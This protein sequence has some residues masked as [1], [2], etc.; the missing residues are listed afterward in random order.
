MTKQ[1]VLVTGVSGYVASYVVDVLIKE[2]YAVRGTV[3]SGKLDALR[4][5]P[6]STKN[7]DKFSV[8]AIDDV[9]T[10]DFTEALKDVNAV[11]HVASP[12]AGNGTPTETLNSARNGTL[13]VLRQATAQ[14]IYKVVV[15][16]S[17]GAALDPTMDDVY[18]GVT[19]TADSWGKVDEN[20]F[21]NGTHSP[22]WSYLAAKIFA[23]KA[24]WEFAKSNPSLDLA[25]INPPFIY[26]PLNLDFPLPTVDRLGPN[27][28]LHALISGEPGR[29]LGPQVPPFYVD[30]RDV[31][32]AHVRALSVPPAEYKRYL[33]SAGHFTFKEAVNY[34]ADAH[35]ELRPRLPSLEGAVPLAGNLSTI[36]ASKAAV[37]L[38]LTNYIPW[39]KM[40]DDA[41]TSMV[42]SENNLKL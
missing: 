30:V 37:D 27:M 20:D 18:N 7:S 6:I 8:V 41:V 32:L 35:P 4:T 2:G 36:D 3:R 31:A 24:A 38:K 14:G 19:Y 28:R 40:V 23:E 12:L 22:F 25:T 39:Q 1:L 11:I 26:G 42:K 15:T 5:A 33:V 9:A 29:P 17:W 13:N 34:I 10:A 16:S 21:L